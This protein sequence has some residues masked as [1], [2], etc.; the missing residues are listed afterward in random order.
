MPFHVINNS[1]RFCF[2]DKQIKDKAGFHTEPL[3]IFTI[4]NNL[5]E[6]IKLKCKV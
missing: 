1:Y 4:E 6:G 2:L 5:L 3:N